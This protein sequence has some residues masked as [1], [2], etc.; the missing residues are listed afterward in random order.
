MHEVIKQAIQKDPKSTDGQSEELL[1]LFV[2]LLGD[3]NFK[4][5][6]MSLHIINLLL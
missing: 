6:L 3:Q 2:T 5:V 4:I 1:D